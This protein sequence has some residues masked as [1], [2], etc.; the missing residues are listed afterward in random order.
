[1]RINHSRKL[2]DNCEVTKAKAQIST[3]ITALESDV[4]RSSFKNNQFHQQLRVNAY[5]LEG[6]IYSD[7]AYDSVEISL[8]AFKKALA[9]NPNH[10]IAKE[11]LLNLRIRLGIASGYPIIRNSF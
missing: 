11:N 8:A 6:I 5:V 1:M 10:E 4:K 3:L 9:L 7:G 2:F